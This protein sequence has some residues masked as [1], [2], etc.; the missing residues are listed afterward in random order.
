MH[1]GGQ[2]FRDRYQEFAGRDAVVL[3]VSADP[4]GE[5]HEFAEKEDLPFRLL[6]DE[7]GEVAT[8]YESFG[9]REVRGETWEI[10]FR[11]TYVIGPDGVIEATYEGVSP[12]DHSDQV[13]RDLDDLME[14][15]G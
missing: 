14:A 9:E 4:V 6:S 3:G 15:T 10:A 11:N 12:E 2:G 1:N 7:E 13:L 5:I 8:R